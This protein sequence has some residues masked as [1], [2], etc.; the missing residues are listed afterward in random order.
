MIDWHCRS[1]M[2]T[3]SFTYVDGGSW[4]CTI[5]MGAISRGVFSLSVDCNG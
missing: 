2:S 5:K 4:C 3:C 1:F